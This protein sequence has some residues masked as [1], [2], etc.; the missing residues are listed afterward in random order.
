MK[1]YAFA[2][3]L[4]AAALT[5]CSQSRHAIEPS[6]PKVVGDTITMPTNA[7]Q[8][9]SLTV[10]PVEEQRPLSVRLTGRLVWDENATARV[11]TPFAG[12]VRKVT[13]EINQPITRGQPLAEIQSAE[14]GQAQAELRKAGSDFRRADRNLTRAKELFEHGAAPRKDLD[15]AEADYTSSEA[16]KERA[17]QRL[18]IYGAVTISTNSNF[19]L[20]SPLDGILV[21]RNVTP[22]QEVRPDQMLANLPQITAPLFL[23]TDPSRLWSLIDASE[24]DLT[25][26]Q[27]GQNFTFNTWAFPNQTFTGT[28]SVVSQFIDPATRTVKVR[29]A[30]DNSG[31]QLKAEMFV[32]IALPDSQKTY[33]ASV[34]QK[35]VFLKGNKHYVFVEEQ[36]GQFARHEVEVG[37]EQQ[38]QI[39]IVAGLSAGQ[40][41]VTDGCVLLQQLLQ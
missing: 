27:P 39:A 40:R 10:E 14:F 20:P 24:E 26:L 12:I 4:L 23:V 33:A 18:A 32:T 3:T 13:G 2:S 21:E 1:T 25:H 11:F 19:L 22:G 6:E 30:V 34:P 7:P 8:R 9:A 31:G 5:A 41:V 29:G 37:P 15:T 36:P 28:V 17:E 35:A 38:G 16:E